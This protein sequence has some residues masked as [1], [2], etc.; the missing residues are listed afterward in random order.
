MPLSTFYNLDPKKQEKIVD[1]SIKEFAK[2]GYKNTT[3]SSIAK[4]AKIS[5]GSMYQYFKSK[6]ELY[7]YIFDISYRDKKRHIKN[8]ININEL[9][10]FFSLLET[11]FMEA[12][13]FSLKHPNLQKIYFDLLKNTN[14]KLKNKVLNRYKTDLENDNFNYLHYLKQEIDKKKIKSG[15]DKKLAA[16]IVSSFLENFSLLLIEK[17]ILTKNM[18]IQKY[19][20]NFIKILK[21]GIKKD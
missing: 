19:I 20:K 17:D 15:V 9:E 4:K 16:F 1:I 21:N 14:R 18:E 8:A 3:V 10:D 6:E 13:L 11:L 2:Y 5:K 12:Y 7:I